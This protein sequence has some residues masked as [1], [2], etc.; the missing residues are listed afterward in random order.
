MKYISDLLSILVRGFLI[1]PVVLI[2]VIFNMSFLCVVWHM[3][4]D[5]PGNTL[6]F[7]R[8]VMTNLRSISDSGFHWLAWLV[9]VG[10]I[11]E[12]QLR[13]V[14]SVNGLERAL[15]RLAILVRGT[16]DE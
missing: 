4:F 8:S 9:M 2:L 11:I 3:V 1:W 15:R 13:V 10:L 6:L 7:C 12:M 16:A 5:G 14:S